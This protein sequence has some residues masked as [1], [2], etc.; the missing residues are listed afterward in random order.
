M[1]KNSDRLTP[2]DRRESR[3][4]RLEKYIKF[5]IPPGKENRKSKDRR[6]FNSG[7]G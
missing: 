1:K 6:E 3:D 5:F 4:Q 2:V 7:R